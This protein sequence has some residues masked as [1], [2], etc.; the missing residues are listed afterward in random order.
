M[1]HT[2]YV[3]K[4][5]VRP[6]A[7]KDVLDRVQAAVETAL[8]ESGATSERCRQISEEIVRPIS[9][10][11]AEARPATLLMPHESPERKA[12]LTF[13]EA[14][15]AT[16]APSPLAVALLLEI[17]ALRQQPVR[18]ASGADRSEPRA[19]SVAGLHVDQP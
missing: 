19:G 6:A 16:A 1:L 8:S 9:H 14:F 7:D 3:I 12:R 15:A 13:A 4:Q 5:T 17:A 18:P 11:L 2:D 10:E